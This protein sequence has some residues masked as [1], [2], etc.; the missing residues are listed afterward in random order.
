VF[1]RWSL[2]GSKREK[3]HQ[4]QVVE[5]VRLSPKQAIHLVTVGDRQLLIG[6]T[7]QNV[8]LLTS[9]ELYL[10]APEAQIQQPMVKTDFSSLFQTINF[11]SSVEVSDKG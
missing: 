8:S 9:V 1:R 11:R 3:K 10:T 5:T 6:A 7:D 4:M 2:P